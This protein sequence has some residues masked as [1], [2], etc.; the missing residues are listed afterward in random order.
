MS[1][2]AFILYVLL[3]SW[4]RPCLIVGFSFTNPF[5]TLFASRLI[6]LSCHPVIPA[7]LLFN[8][9]L[10]GLFWACCMLSFCP[11]PIAQHYHWASTHA[12][13]GYLGTFHHSLAS[14]A[15]F[16]LLV[17]LSPFHLLRHP[18]PI[19][20]LHSHGLLLSILGFPDPNY[21][22][23][24]FRGLWAFPPTPYLLNFLLWASLAH[25]CLLFVSHNAHGFTTSFSR[26]L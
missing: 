2:W 7:M 4:A 24:Y 25:S 9:W 23:L 10:L 21:H 16:I 1:L 11:I 14:L 8:L 12:V 26:L 22:I 20:I 15:Y 17:I 18:Q 3:I 6:H 19:P 5:L 13:L